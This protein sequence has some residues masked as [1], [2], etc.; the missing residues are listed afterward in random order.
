MRWGLKW[1]SKR[2]VRKSAISFFPATVLQGWSPDRFIFLFAPLHDRDRVE[3]MLGLGSVDLGSST[4]SV[5][6]EGK[7]IDLYWNLPCANALLGTSAVIFQLF[8]LGDL[9]QLLGTLWI[10]KH[11]YSIMLGWNHSSLWVQ[12]SHSDSKIPRKSSTISPKYI[13]QATK[14]KSSHFFE[15][16]AGQFSARD[17]TS[18]VLSA[19]ALSGHGQVTL[20]NVLQ[21]VSSSEYRDNKDAKTW[22]SHELCGSV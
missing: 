12:F 15:I 11:I 4:E 7:G 20:C 8:Y 21:S 19:T 1:W 6:K 13:R 5:L 18:G 2:A 3:R 22:E 9:T 16:K 17:K 10:F 14:F